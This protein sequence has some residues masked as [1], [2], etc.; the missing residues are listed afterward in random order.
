[1][2]LTINLYKISD[3][4][5]VVTKTLGT[6]L[7]VSGVAR[8]SFPVTG[9]TITVETSTDITKYNYCYVQDT[10]R[11]YYIDNID[12]LRNT[13]YLLDLKVDVLMTYDAQIR[14]LTGTVDR[15]ENLYNGYIQDGKYNALA[16]TQIVAKTFPNGMTSD[17]LILMTV[18]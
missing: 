6:A 10:G 8:G 7:D 12:I 9:G 15:Q 5:N 16:Y 3:D 18:G 4:K 14:A 1:M 2:S 11:Y 13:L 17:N